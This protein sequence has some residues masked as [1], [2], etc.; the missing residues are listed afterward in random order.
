MENANFIAPQQTAL[1]ENGQIGFERQ[2]PNPALIYLISLSSVNSRRTMASILKRVAALAG[3]ASIE[4]M[5]WAKLE[6]QHV[7]LIMQKLKKE[8]LSPATRN[9]YLSAVKRV[10]KEAWLSGLINA[11][12]YQRIKEVNASRGRRINTKGRALTKAERLKLLNN[13]QDTKQSSIADIRDRAI[14]AVML[15]CGLRKSE[16][17]SLRPENLYLNEGFFT[18]IGKGDIEAKVVIPMQVKPI[19]K[20][21]LDAKQMETEYVFAPINRHGQLY[22]ARITGEGISYI[23]KMRS[24][25]TDV[26]SFS[27]HD[28]RRTF[29]TQL[30]ASGADLLTVRDALRHQS[31]ETTQIYVMQD[32]ERLRSAIE[33]ADLV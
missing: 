12:A 7:M 13:N 8:G 2:A 9:T 26:D 14:I 15:G 6:R 16:V 20:A 18:V 5:P 10:A 19:L 33:G 30:L 1:S 3:Y 11:E 31:V 32:D 22:N 23:L 27:P 28:T 4:T 21:W 29:A 17:C 24:I 25:R